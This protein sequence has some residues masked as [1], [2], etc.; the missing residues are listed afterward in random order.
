M[1]GRFEKNIGIAKI[2]EPSAVAAYLAPM[3]VHPGGILCECPEMGFTGTNLIYCR[4]GLS[5]PFFKIQQGWKVLIE[6]TYNGDE[7]WF[8]TGIAD[9]T[10]E[11]TPT[12]ADQMILQ[13]VSQVIYA[14]SQGTLH[15]SSDTATEPFVLGNKLLTWITTFINTIFNLHT[16]SFVGVAPGVTSTTAVPAPTGTPPTDILSVKIFGE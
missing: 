15:L 5:I 14:S 2:V 6:P 1:L 9:C 3:A 8:Y 11:I 12:E 16:H 10:G 7:R 13:F 4:Y